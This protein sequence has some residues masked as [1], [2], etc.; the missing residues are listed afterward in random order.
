MN[1]GS[2]LSRLTEYDKKVMNRYIDLYAADDNLGRIK[3]KKS[4]ETIFEHWAENKENL[5]K[6]FPED[7]LTIEEEVFYKKDINQIYAEMDKS[8]IISQFRDKLRAAW[9]EYCATSGYTQH[10]AAWYN[11]ADLVCNS[12][13]VNNKYDYDPF[14]IYTADKPIKI[15]Q[16]MKASRAIIKVAET[17]GMSA[18]D[19]EEF[20]LEHSRLL[21]DVEVHGKMVFSI[22][23]MDFM[24]MSDN[25]CRW[26]SCMS[27]TNSGEYRQGT[28]EMMNSPYIVEAYIASDRPYC[29]DANDPDL[30]WNNKKWRELFIV[31]SSCVMGIKGYPYWNRDLE[32][33]ALTKLKTLAT[34]KLGYQYEDFIREFECMDDYSDPGTLTDEDGNYYYFSTEYMYNDFRYTHYGYIMS[35]GVMEIDINYSGPCQ[36]MLCGHKWEVDNAEDLTC[37]CCHD[38]IYTCEECGAEVN[39]VTCDPETG[40]YICW[41]C[42]R[43]KYAFDTFANQFIPVEDAALV[44]INYDNGVICYVYLRTQWLTDHWVEGI[45]ELDDGQRIVVNE[46]TW[47]ELRCTYLDETRY[48]DEIELP[49]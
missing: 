33:I 37:E 3:H 24:T 9:R 23:P 1:M 41:D 16:G 14:T 17:I 5:G 48:T 31:S 38:E 49:F 2:L 21:N 46:E 28:V 10:N 12:S 35:D 19:I 32:K 34:E 42:F 22:H 43:K 7:K 8:D 13:L 20:R 40:K 6:M 11:I 18:A 45:Q 44:E 36:C 4:I 29:F 25:D 26:H 30:M 27:W 47:K 15:C 39:D